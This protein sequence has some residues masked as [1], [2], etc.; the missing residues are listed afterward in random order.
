MHSTAGGAKPR[1]GV[2]EGREKEGVVA[3]VGWWRGRLSNRGRMGRGAYRTTG[4][5]PN[6]GTGAALQSHHS[7]QG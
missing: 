6:G 1:L 4:T 3:E 5:Q 7:S 2:E